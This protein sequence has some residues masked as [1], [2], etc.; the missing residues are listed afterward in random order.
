MNKTLK[1][2]IITG[3]AAMLGSFSY[4]QNAAPVA[5][6]PAAAPA[7]A[8]AQPAA[9]QEA[10]STMDQIL[11]PSLK[12][13]SA[14]VTVGYESNY[15]FRGI[16]YSESSI[17]PE[18]ALGYALT[19]ALGVY[20]SAWSTTPFESDDSNEIDFNLGATY[21][22]AGFTFDAGYTHYWYTSSPVG[23][24]TNELKIGVSYDTSAVLSKVSSIFADLAITPSV[25][26]FYDLD[27]HA[28][29]VEVAVSATAP[30]S[31]WFL[32]EDKDFLAVESSL[33]YGFAT[34][35]RF[36][37]DLGWFRNTD[38]YSYVGANVDLVWTINDMC[39]ASIGIRWAANNNNGAELGF[40]RNG[41]NDEQLLW[42]G[43]SVSMGF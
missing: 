3:F 33:Y 18:I 17:Q 26:Y 43:G 30:V 14:S 40:P 9:Q 23:L 13:F 24:S 25:Y 34:G 35:D 6:A 1:T 5:T 19:D 22:I 28:N 15:V 16:K 10:P 42:G 21:A 32:G 2:T 31:K 38:S 12:K 39:K 29:T 20:A 37:S 41:S 27:L 7:V 8:Q 4:A 36:K 11:T